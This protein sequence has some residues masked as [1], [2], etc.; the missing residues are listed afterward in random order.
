MNVPA[1]S[2]YA[3]IREMTRR[4]NN[5]MNIIW[6][7]AAVSVSRSGYYHYLETEDLRQQREEQDRKDFLIILEAYKFRGYS[8]GARGI[9]M[10]L[11]HIAPPVHMNIKKI[12]RLALPHTPRFSL[13]FPGRQCLLVIKRS[14][15]DTHR[16]PCKSTRSLGSLLSVALSSLVVKHG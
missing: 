9:Y 14:S 5:L 7:C 4:D 6:L 15:A 8:K 13:W 12:R 1:S 16:L 2:K 10:R 3:T 11:L